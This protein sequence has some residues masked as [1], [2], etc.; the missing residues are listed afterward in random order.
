M[1]SNFYAL[2]YRLRSIY[3]WSGTRALQ[4]EDVAQH[5]YGVALVSHALCEI[6]KSIYN[7]EIDTEKVVIYSLYHD[8][9]DSM[10]THIIAPIKNFNQNTKNTFNE[11]K[12][13]SINHLLNMLPNELYDVY[14]STLHG[15]FDEEIIKVVH[16]ADQIDAFI[17]CKVEYLRGNAEFTNAYEQTGASIKRLSEEYLYVKYFMETFMESFE[18]LSAEYRYLK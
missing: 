12:T 9:T 2:L 11:L 10:L 8:A 5:S 6:K 17:K 3:R 4:P 16:I 14:Y 15:K 18:F 7:E 1:Q 13:E